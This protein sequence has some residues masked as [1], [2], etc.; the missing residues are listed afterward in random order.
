MCECAGIGGLT[1]LP[2][3]MSQTQFLPLLA[4]AY[5]LLHLG[6]DG[7]TFPEPTQA[8]LEA[9]A[10]AKVSIAAIIGLHGAS[11]S[12]KSSIGNSIAHSFIPSAGPPFETSDTMDTCTI[13]INAV[14]LP[15]PLDDQLDDD[16]KQDRRVIL[17]LDSQGIDNGS[18]EHQQLI[19]GIMAW[20]CTHLI[21]VDA[22]L[23]TH[24]TLGSICSTL[25]LARVSALAGST[26]PLHLRW[27]K[28]IVVA[29]KLT[30]QES[31]DEW[32]KNFMKDASERDGESAQNA[33]M[34]SSIFK[35][36]TYLNLPFVFP[37]EGVPLHHDEA[38]SRA[39]Y[40][41]LIPLLNLE[42][43][44]P[45][46]VDSMQWDLLSRPAAFPGPQ[47]PFARVLIAAMV[48][49]LQSYRG[50]EAAPV[51][52]SR[53]D[54]LVVEI[55]NE[56]LAVASRQLR[57]QSTEQ[58]LTVDA[59]DGREPPAQLLERINRLYQ[60]TVEAYDEKLRTSSIEE[61]LS[62][63]GVTQYARAAGIQSREKLENKFVTL[64]QQLLAQHALWNDVVAEEVEM[65]EA[66]PTEYREDQIS[67]YHTGSVFHEDHQQVYH[68]TRTQTLQSR[69]KQTL[70]NG[71]QRHTGWVVGATQSAVVGSR[72]V[73]WSRPSQFVRICE[74]VAYTAAAAATL[75]AL[76]PAAGAHL[77]QAF[78]SRP[79]NGKRVLIYDDTGNGLVEFTWK[80]GALMYKSYFDHCIAASSWESAIRELASTIGNGA[81]VVELQFWG[82]GCEGVA[83]VGRDELTVASLASSEWQAIRDIFVDN[84]VLW[85]RTCR[86]FN[87]SQGR[88]FANQFAAHF[89]EK[90]KLVGHT[91][92]IGAMHAGLVVKH[93]RQPATW[94]DGSGSQCLCT[95]MP[96]FE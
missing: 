38:F 59:I 4:R 9:L 34:I 3:H 28:L 90:V 84:A 22:S 53:M 47:E 29:N 35:S 73:R 57:I 19:A 85:F 39:V 61:L 94:S 5:A 7:I 37:T 41:R 93:Q 24:R 62:L 2:P 81:R 67:E 12:G 50:F 8:W 31:D 75:G 25:L 13:G 52:V 11:R 40:S 60:E 87:G 65:S 63:N 78:R 76:L 30:L 48:S 95:D 14:A 46:H 72:S 86:T 26:F 92:N 27:P 21:Y 33:K 20:L 80:Y 6:K 16:E 23:I 64:R 49:L 66:A 1:H 71:T 17:L 83:F 96:S 68:T 44:Q 79:S 69:L 70:R 54:H 43:H 91:V 51:E 42:F 58:R 36:N 18:S 77:D 32:W 82:H 10:E 74:A 15:L 89:R 45:P 56:A 88:N 55:F